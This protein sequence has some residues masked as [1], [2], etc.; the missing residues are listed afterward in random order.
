MT[1]APITA[2]D[3]EVVVAHI[4]GRAYPVPAVC[5]VLVPSNGLGTKREPSGGPPRFYIHA[6]VGVRD[7]QPH[8]R[9][10][11]I[12]CEAEVTP[13]EL[14]YVPWTVVAE[15][16]I[17]S[18]VASTKVER[19]QIQSSRTR[20]V[21]AS[22]ARTQRALDSSGGRQDR[23]SPRSDE[24]LREVLRL[25]A[26]AEAKGLRYSAYVADRLNYSE[27]YVRRLAKMARDRGLTP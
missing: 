7:G 25:R 15:A 19:E 1:H 24:R 9:S 3:P 27:A 20:D 21:A 11:S 4:R 10:V 26:E 12:T 17:L 8:F 16:A 13:R 5:G 2:D 22:R 6:E 18:N 23:R 14:Q